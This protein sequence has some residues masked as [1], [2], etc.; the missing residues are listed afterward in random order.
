MGYNDKTAPAS[1]KYRTGTVVNIEAFANQGYEFDH[2]G[3]DL[4]GST[5]PT[6]ITMNSS[7]TIT[8]FFVFRI[9]AKSLSGVRDEINSN[10]DL[11][12][13]DVSSTSDY[14]NSHILCAR[15]YPWNTGS[16]SFDERV[17]LTSLNSYKDDDILIYDQTGGRSHDAADSLATQ[18]FT[19]I[20]YMTDGLDDWIASGYE[21]FMT[22]EDADICTTLPPMA[23]SGDDQNVNEN[24]KVALQGR[25]WDPDGGAVTYEWTQVQGNTPPDLSALTS[26]TLT[27]TS[28]NNLT[29]NETIIFHLT[30]TDNEGD[31]D[32]DSVTV[33]VNW[34]NDK[35]EANAGSDKTIGY[36]AKV[37]LD[38]S[39]SSDPEGEALSYQW[40]LSAGTIT[41]TLSSATAQK[42]IFT[43]PD[44]EGWAILALTVT[45]SGGKTDSETVK[46]TVMSSVED[47]D[48]DGYTTIEGDCDDYDFSV[49]PGITEIC[50]GIDNDCDGSTDEGD[51][52]QNCTDADSDG[53]YI[54]RGCGTAID[55]DDSDA[56]IH[57]GTS[58]TC[59]DGIDQ[60]CDGSDEDCTPDVDDDGDGF[61]GN[62]GDYNDTDSSVYPGADEICG[63]GIDQDCDGNKYCNVIYYPH[64]ASKGSGSWETEICAINS[65]SVSTQGVFKAYD[66]DG[67]A[68]SNTINVT[69]NAHARRKITIGDEFTSPS[70]IGYI[71][72]E[73]DSK[74]VIGYTKFYIDG[75]YRVAVPAISDITTGDLYISHIASNDN[76]WTGVSIVNTTSTT[77]NLT[78]EFNDGTTKDIALAG[79]QHYIF[80][81]KSFF[82]NIPQPTLK[83]AVIKT[84]D[85]VIGLELFCKDDQ[86]SGIL[87]KNDTTKNMYYPH[88]A[89]NDKWWTGIVAYNPSMSSSTLTIKPYASNG[90]GLAT[91]T[92]ILGG[93]KKYIGSV[94]GLGLPSDSAW[95]QIVATSPITGFELFGTSDGKQLAGYTGVNINNTEGIFAK[96]EKDGWTGIAFV[97]IGSSPTTVNLTAYNNSGIMIDTKSIIMDPF[98]KIVNNPGDIFDKSIDNAT[99]ITYSSVEE[100]VGF[101][102]NGFSDGMMLDGLPGM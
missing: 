6:T 100:V 83:S 58:E 57:P 76:W 15:N 68:V 49:N 99:Y 69:L 34:F 45:D 22:A 70:D 79:K 64:I 84:A 97:N 28:F 20:Y 7:K 47:N 14:A 36:G 78:I 90:T 19:S 74:D 42:M 80:N 2:W 33:H 3:G 5:N 87:L 71:I 32:S 66:N 89:S 102:L 60:D 88:I 53:Y 67:N 94:K 91:Q 24:E 93:Q 82:N 92:V 16:K 95:F 85:G 26:S 38:G 50:D 56:S 86:L 27:F 4:S 10:K 55:C 37:Q 43:A 51:A 62:E 72:F 101:Q 18:E 23:Y 39:G 59:S 73:T 46:V 25:G 81:I 65:S 96:I 1:C 31:K 8:A 61:T 77:K 12:V 21:T 63:D 30:V 54:E 35:P 40:M 13:I 75:Q 41:P 44:K 9:T 29:K 48:A 52:C 17:S 98:E 11:I